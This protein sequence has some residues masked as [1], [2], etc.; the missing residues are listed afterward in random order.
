MT[1]INVDTLKHCKYVLIGDNITLNIRSHKGTAN[2]LFNEAI[3][4]EE[5]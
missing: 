4:R 2:N 5:K 3:L 1:N